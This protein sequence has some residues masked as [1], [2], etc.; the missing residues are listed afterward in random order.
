MKRAD[1]L[2][3]PPASAMLDTNCRDS[4]GLMM[5]KI[6]TLSLFAVAFIIQVGAAHADG[7]ITLQQ[8]KHFSLYAPTNCNRIN[9]PQFDLVLDCK[10]KEKRARFYLKEYPHMSPPDP[11]L[12]SGFDLNAEF[13]R[14]IRVM[15]KGVDQNIGERI[16]LFGGTGVA[17]GT[18]PIFNYYGFSY[19]TVEAAKKNYTVDGAEKRVFFRTQSYM[20]GQGFES[21]ILVVIC[22][23]D[24]S[25]MKR[26]HGVPD[27]VITM[28][29]SLD[30]VQNRLP[31]P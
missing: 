1:G 27:E 16:K 8:A 26:N 24:R 13:E 7:D 31:P 17:A 5:S 6:C 14:L 19:P 3:A 4:N 10:F 30:L 18:L 21:A 25:N 23:Y 28:L 12:Y 20:G 11:K 29:G 2:I 22:D 15:F 9:V